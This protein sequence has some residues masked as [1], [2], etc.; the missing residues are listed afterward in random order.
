MDEYPEFEIV[1]RY[2]ARWRYKRA[3]GY[4]WSWTDETERDVAVLLENAEGWAD[5]VARF[6]EVAVVG[7]V[8]PNTC[9]NFN[10]REVRK[11]GGGDGIYR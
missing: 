11:V 6:P 8:T 4:L 9:M 1:D 3:E 10:L 7:D 2:G 5:E